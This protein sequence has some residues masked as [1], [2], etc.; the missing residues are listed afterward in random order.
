[1]IYVCKT[2][3]YYDLQSLGELNDDDIM[4]K[5]LIEIEKKEGT[6]RIDFPVSL[7][8]ALERRNNLL[9]HRLMKDNP[10]PNAVDSVGRTALVSK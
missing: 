2:C 7:G 5:V 1:L 9:F 6:G 10:D 4:K 8:F 3:I